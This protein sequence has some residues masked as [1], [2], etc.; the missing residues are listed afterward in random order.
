MGKDNFDNFDYFEKEEEIPESRNPVGA[1]SII[2]AGV[3]LVCL[4]FVF[5]K[6]LFSSNS[7]T[8]PE[9]LDT[10][11][12]NTDI[13]E[14]KEEPAITGDMSGTVPFPAGDM[15]GG[16]MVIGDGPPDSGLVSGAASSAVDSSKAEGMGTMYVTEYAYLHTAPSE[17]AEN[18]VCMSPGIGVTVLSKDEMTG[19][20]KVT[21]E[22]IDE[23]L[24]G[25][26]HKDYLSETQT[27]VP[28]WEQ[29]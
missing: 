1:A 19:Y 16:S 9:G 18:I 20:Y 15:S 29:W 8:V 24:T 4:I 2:V 22:N 17:E 6:V 7:D 11:T 10:A 27:V 5:A 14:P 12:I 26:V 25:Y 23:P 3:F 13:T 21:F 28:E